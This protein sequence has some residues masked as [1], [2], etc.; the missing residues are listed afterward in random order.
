MKNIRKL[1]VQNERIIKRILRK[2]M[3]RLDDRNI[4][5]SYDHEA[6]ILS[7]WVFKDIYQLVKN[8]FNEGYNEGGRLIKQYQVHA[9]ISVDDALI[10][11]YADILINRLD[12]FVFVN[13]DD[14][15]EDIAEW[16]VLGYSH[17]HKVDLLLNYFDYEAIAASRFS[18][19]A[20][21]DIYN[22]ASV[23]RYKDSGVVDGVKFGAH[24]DNRT[25]EICLMLNGTIWALDDPEKETPP[26]HFNCRS[27]LIPYFGVIPKTRDFTKDFTD[28][29]IEQAEKIKE[30]FEN[31]YWSK[32]VIDPH[33]IL[34]D[35]ESDQN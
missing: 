2:F 19:T 16:T 15:A 32:I 33:D 8:T 23:H 7:S 1:E 25:S 34:P 35:D 4:L 22:N 31:K 21:N 6:K 27:R 9:A 3:H 17:D 14:L 24:I 29:F 5:R 11:E 13:R 20:T 12:A 18:R 26:M 30:T 10:Y 28:E